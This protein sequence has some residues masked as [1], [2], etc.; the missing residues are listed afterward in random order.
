M[1][2]LWSFLEVVDLIP[3]VGLPRLLSLCSATPLSGVG[4]SGNPGEIQLAACCTWQIAAPLWHAQRRGGLSAR[5][6]PPEGHEAAPR[7]G[8]AYNCYF[9]WRQILADLANGTRI[10]S[11]LASGLTTRRIIAAIGDSAAT[12]GSGDHARTLTRRRP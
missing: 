4:A 10:A 6:S 7:P 1:V 9:L 5:W 12:G 2:A 8:P 3:L 11:D